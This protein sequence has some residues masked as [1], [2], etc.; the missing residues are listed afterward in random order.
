MQVLWVARIAQVGLLRAVSCLDIHVSNWA[1]TSHTTL[2]SLIGY[3]QS[4]TRLCMIGLDANLLAI[5]ACAYLL[6]QIFRIHM[7]ISGICHA[8]V[9][10]SVVIC[11]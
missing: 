1:P 10:L 11:T 6:I 4:S 7:A 9:R 8:S 3:V 5:Y 2:H